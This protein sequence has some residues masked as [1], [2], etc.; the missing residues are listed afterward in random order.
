MYFSQQNLHL[1]SQII[2]VLQF[3]GGPRNPIVYSLL[4]VILK[5]QLVNFQA[6]STLSNLN[7]FLLSPKIK[8]KMLKILK[9][10]LY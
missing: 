7:P 6:V 1:E 8:Y 4:P 9:V 10:A 3:L 2:I 5:L